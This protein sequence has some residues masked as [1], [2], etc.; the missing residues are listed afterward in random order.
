M[1]GH[2]PSGVMHERSLVKHIGLIQ[3]DFDDVLDPQGYKKSLFNDEHILMAC[4]SP[5]GNGVKH[6]Q[7]LIPIVIRQ[8]KMR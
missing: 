4:V 6:W 2:E 7:Q 3:V 1:D 8:P 5:R